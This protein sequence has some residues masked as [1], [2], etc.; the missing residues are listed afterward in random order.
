MFDRAVSG[1]HWAIDREEW[2]AAWE[3]RELI[4][5][6]HDLAEKAAA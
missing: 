1:Y 6:I 3:Y 4:D 2:T 5:Q